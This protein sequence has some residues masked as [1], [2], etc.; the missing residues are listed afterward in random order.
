MLYLSCKK[1]TAWK[2]FETSVFLLLLPF[3]INMSEFDLFR[4]CNFTKISLINSLDILD[5]GTL[6]RIILS[7]AICPLSNVQLFSMNI[8]MTASVSECL[9]SRSLETSPK[10]S[11]VLATVQHYLDFQKLPP[12]GVPRKRCSENMQQFYRN[13]QKSTHAEV[14]FQWSCFATLLNHISAWAFSSKFVA[15]YQNTSF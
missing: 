10:L 4:L 11:K 12:R 3:A 1:Y 5:L 8:S 13:L 9:W 7:S 15:Y 14:W 2:V 6:L